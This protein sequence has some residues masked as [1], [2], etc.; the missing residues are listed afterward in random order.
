MPYTLNEDVANKYRT[1]TFRSDST[2]CSDKGKTAQP[3]KLKIKV[4]I[5]AIK[6]M[7]ILE[8]LGNIVSFT[9]NFKPSAKGCNKPKT[10][11]TLGPFLL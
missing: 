10:P 5:G 9:N 1:P 6:N 4:S 11:T 3:I 8:L 2:I 7:L